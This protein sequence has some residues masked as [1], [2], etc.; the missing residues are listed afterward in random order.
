MKYYKKQKIGEN[1]LYVMVWLAILLVP[2]LNSKMM[3][4]VHVSL[5][6]IL[7]AWQQIAPLSVH[8]HHPQRLHRALRQ[9]PPVHALRRRRRAL[10]LGGLLRRRHPRQH[11]GRLRHAGASHQRQTRVVHRPARLLEHRAGTLHDLRQHRHQD[12]VPVAA[13]RAGH[14][15]SSNDR[16]SR[17]KWTI[18]NT[19]STPISS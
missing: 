2:I 10:H 6:N 4:E 8:L 17:P 19:R 15:R 14:G 9:A 12:D 7:I 18:S 3:S 5:S 1:L 13:R 11:T 16:T